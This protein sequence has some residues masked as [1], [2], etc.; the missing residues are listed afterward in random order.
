MEGNEM[1][2]AF[3]NRVFNRRSGL[4]GGRMGCTLV[5]G[6]L[7]SGKTTLLKHLLDNRGDLRLAVLVNEFADS[8]VDSL[9]LDATRLNQAF[10]L[11]TVSLTHGCACCD[12]SGPFRE[13]LQRIVDSRHNFDCLL[14]ETSGLARPD[15]F[16][17][18]LK[19]VGIHLDLTVAVVDAESLDKIINIDIVRRQLQHVDIVLLNKCDLATLSQISNAED[20]LEGLTGGARV[21]R[22]QFCRVPL[23]LV[24]DCTKLQALDV[25][26]NFDS[27]PGI[28]SHESLPKMAF[29]HNN[30]PV[31]ISSIGDTGSQPSDN[32][33]A[34]FPHGASFSSASF[35]TEVP[36]SLALFQSKVL[37]IMRCSR[38]LIRAKG[39]IWFA[40]DRE[41][42]F[43]FQWSGLKRVEAVSGQ[44]WE[45]SPKSRVV[46]IGTDN[47]ELQS[48]VLQLSASANYQRVVPLEPGTVGEH[49]RSFSMMVASDSRFKEPSSKD[50]LV[51]FGLKGSPL[52]GVKESHLSGALMRLINGRGK[53]FVTATTSGEEYNLQ[54]L[55]DEG[56]GVN[57]AWDEIR[58]AT[59]IVI[60]KIC[61]NFCP[62]RSDLTAHV[63]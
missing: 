6:F 56:T 63:H 36:L 53:I 46:L 15:K 61:K 16:V 19:E 11:S 51:V 60:S 33:D 18:D 2:A 45:S 21:V 29:R 50:P 55:L 30:A 26:K 9:L 59:S 22:S 41:N 40:E 47:S 17:A 39:I 28:L 43:V 62:C 1:S 37:N 34:G 12:V 54:L 20:I 58:S 52:R 5:T 8:D 49:A 48:I 38:S 13:S 24:I 31:Q 14:V 7:G 32:F 10:N 27:M 57:T 44:P 25:E 42:R 23:D 35:E 4:A 3:E